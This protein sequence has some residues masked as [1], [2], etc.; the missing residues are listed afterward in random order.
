M[1]VW[2]RASADNHSSHTGF[3]F[4][5]RSAFW[6]LAVKARFI[7]SS[8]NHTAQALSNPEKYCTNIHYSLPYARL[9]VR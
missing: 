3:E 1:F 8:N 5:Q 4:L 2:N 7:L 6:D 9:G